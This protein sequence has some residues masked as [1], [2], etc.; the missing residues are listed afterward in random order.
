M[1]TTTYALVAISLEQKNARSMLT[2]LQNKIMRSNW[3]NAVIFDLCDLKAAF[4]QL[5]QF[6]KYCRARK[7]EAYIIPAIRRASIE[8]DALLDELEN[9]SA[10]GLRMIRS[11]YEQIQLTIKKGVVNADTFFSSMECYCQNLRKRLAKEE[12]EL[13]PVAERILSFDQWFAVAVECLSDEENGQNYKLPITLEEQD[14][15]FTESMQL[16]LEKSDIEMSEVPNN[17]RY[18]AV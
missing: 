4:K 7:I 3:N 10:Q 6:D 16:Y 17:Y 1:L 8:I 13:L 2:K 18:S 11:L 12:Q 14:I 9:L 5:V 15:Y